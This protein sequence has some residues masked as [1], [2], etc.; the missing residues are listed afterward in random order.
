MMYGMYP[1]FV[2]R[3]EFRVLVGEKRD[4]G[5]WKKV[6]EGVRRISLNR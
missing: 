3:L 6:E 1:N 4:V 2:I 5:W